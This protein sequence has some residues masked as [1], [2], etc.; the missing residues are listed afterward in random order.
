MNVLVHNFVI[1]M[2]SN[3]EHDTGHVWTNL[4]AMQILGKP[5]HGCH[6]VLSKPNFQNT[7]SASVITDHKTI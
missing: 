1:L 3:N 7:V 2:S 6:F 4:H 5:P